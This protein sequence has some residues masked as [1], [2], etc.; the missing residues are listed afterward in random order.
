MLY[1]NNEN[2]YN[3]NTGIESTSKKLNNI[4]YNSPSSRNKKYIAI[5]PYKRSNK[6]I[7]VQLL[8]DKKERESNLKKE[9]N[10]LNYALKELKDFIPIN[11][12]CILINK[13]P[14]KIISKAKKFLMKKGYFCSNK[15]NEYII[16]AIKGC[17]NIEINLYKLKYLNNIDNVY[18][19]VR[20]KNKNLP[21]E[22]NLMN[23]L[24]NYI[25]EDKI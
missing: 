10:K 17:S 2:Y 25:N 14:N 22:K 24:I 12:N 23:K 6:K 4:I 1:N 8:S 16:K 9:N 5:S 20:I 7:S 19:S 21:Q 3:I 18:L 13:S 11:L 15:I